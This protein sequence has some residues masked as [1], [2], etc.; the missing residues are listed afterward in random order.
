MR[1]LTVNDMGHV[2]KK[3]KDETLSSNDNSNYQ[4]GRNKPPLHG[5]F[6]A[7]Q[8]GNIKGRRPGT[9]NRAAFLAEKRIED[10]AEPLIKTLI[11]K[12]K[13]G[14]SAELR[15]CV[16]RILPPRRERPLQFSLPEL[17]TPAD[18]LK[19]IGKIA[20]A[21]SH[22]ELSESQA[23]VLIDLVRTFVETRNA[24]DNDARL[25]VVEQ[26]L[27]SRSIR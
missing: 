6:K 21:V 14:H 10:E 11:E 17:N 19:A 12:A 4:V 7:G 26:D 23:K 2:M 18:A 5:R 20:E 25:A 9:K 3:W 8:S 24:V 15:L 1:Q 13:E 27:S 16:E 22:G